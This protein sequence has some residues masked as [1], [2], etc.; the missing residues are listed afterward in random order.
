[1]NNLAEQRALTAAP[2]E[3]DPSDLDLSWD[4]ADW[5]G[6][7]QRTRTVEWRMLALVPGDD[8]TS[9][10][11]VANLIQR[12]ALDHGET[13]QVADTRSLRLKHLDAFL[14]GARRHVGRGARILFATPS[15][16]TSPT[17]VS[18]ARAAD[19]AILCVSLGLTRTKAARTTIEQIGPE[20]FM[21]SLLVRAPPV[22]ADGKARLPRSARS[23][24]KP[25]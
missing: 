18:L 7:W 25:P 5:Q 3:P 17:T 14:E 2:S 9:T 12:L 20:H 15:A 21:G 13:V 16:L 6:M 19:C 8:Q 1:M 24:K 11:G 23:A 4:R 22:V 10:L